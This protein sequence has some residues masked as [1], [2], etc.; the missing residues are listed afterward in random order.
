MI[1][2]SS[3]L[4]LFFFSGDGSAQSNL[5][6][7]EY[8]TVPPHFPLSLSPL[9]GKG[10]NPFPLFFFPLF[11]FFLRGLVLGSAPVPSFFFPLV[12]WITFSEEPVGKGRFPFFLCGKS[13]PFFP[14]LFFFSTST[15]G[16]ADRLLR[17][18]NFSFFCV[19]A[20]LLRAAI[21]PP[22][23]ILVSPS[24]P[25]LLFGLL[26]IRQPST[27]TR[28][29]SPF[30]F[31]PVPGQLFFPPPQG[32]GRYSQASLGVERSPPFLPPFPL[33]SR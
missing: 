24:P 10:G 8:A 22:G 31:F 19:R 12:R 20:V 3:V 25:F 33:Q 29:L 17:N 18:R 27:E 2:I 9:V 7:V 1:G 23:G 15:E 13:L 21:P 11:F 5:S 16:G 26:I 30:F 28:T 4:P 32:H 14:S 6:R